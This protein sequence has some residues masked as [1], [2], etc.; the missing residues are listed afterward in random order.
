MKKAFKIIIIIVTLVLLGFVLKF[1]VDSNSKSIIEYET[2]LPFYTSLNT[3]VV[4]TGK[5]NPED[6][7][8]LNL[9]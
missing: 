5:L 6:E 4:A 7:I 2:Q 1:F 8:E 9:K 3:N